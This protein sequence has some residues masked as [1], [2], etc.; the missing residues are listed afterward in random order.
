MHSCL[1]AAHDSGGMAAHE[2]RRRRPAV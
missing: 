2:D 1:H